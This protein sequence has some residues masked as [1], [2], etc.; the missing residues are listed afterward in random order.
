MTLLKNEGRH[1][2][3]Y[4]YSDQSLEKGE[5]FNVTV[6]RDMNTDGRGIKHW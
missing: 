6:L 3:A 5:P 4:N 2:E 1:K